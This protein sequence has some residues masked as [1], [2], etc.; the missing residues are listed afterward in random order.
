MVL[1]LKAL[2]AD[3]GEREISSDKPFFIGRGPEN[4]W[5]LADPGREIS[6]VHCRIDADG[7]AYVLTDMSINGVHLDREGRS[8][9]RGSRHRLAPGDLFSIGQHRFGVAAPSGED[10]V[11][12]SATLTAF[13][14]VRGILGGEAEGQEPRASAAIA[15]EA[16]SWL[17]TLP[18]GAATDGL[19]QPLGWTAPPA[20]ETSILPP[21]VDQPS[22]ELANVS[23]HAA[24]TAE[25]LIAPRAR[26]VLPLDWNGDG[27]AGQG[28]RALHPEV[29]P[30]PDPTSA[31]RKLAEG[32]R[33]AEVGLGTMPDGALFQRA[34]E[35]IRAL[36]DGLDAIEAAQAVAEH[37]C[38]LA[39]S[40]D[41]GLW[42]DFLTSTRDPCLKL[43]TEPQAEA[44]EAL[45]RRIAGLAE[46]Q[47]ALGAATVEAVRAWDERLGPD[48]I[49]RDTVPPFAVGPLGKAVLWT[50]YVAAHSE[51][52]E[53]DADGDQ[54]RPLMRLLRTA[55]NRRLSGL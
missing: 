41:T 25:S 8:L 3:G 16:Q 21:D 9:G 13:E 43:L 1:V 42:T 48:S 6:K 47:R 32:A 55:F 7:D 27:E 51:M 46:R 34:G 14:P 18:S 26:P 20:T 52:A 38:G 17:G 31:R 4:D 40:D 44:T 2:D 50:R 29:P 36:V 39:I 54:G 28:P 37:D 23:E 15:G 33:V 53:V 5:V 35:L 12:A 45:A 49:A 30:N 11:L 19:A 10:H 24:A 22:S